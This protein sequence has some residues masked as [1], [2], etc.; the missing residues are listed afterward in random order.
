VIVCVPADSD[1]TAG[2]RVAVL[3]T[4]V[5]V[6]R[7]VPVPTAPSKNVTVP[8]GAPL[9]GDVT[10]TVAAN[11]TPWPKTDPGG[12]TGFAVTDTDVS[13]LMTVMLSGGALV[14]GWKWLSPLYRAVIV[15]GLTRE[16]LE[17]TNCA[18][19]LLLSI[20]DDGVSLPSMVRRAEPVTV[21]AAG[22]VGAT[23]T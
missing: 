17:I 6:P 22:G 2:V 19:P 11:V 15:C 5:A 3:P 14:L 10:L 4:R 16:R 18:W 21:P 8:V 23:C 9:P 12:M 20:T 7:F 13:A 1:V